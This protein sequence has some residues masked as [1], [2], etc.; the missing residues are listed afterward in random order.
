MRLF[1]VVQNSIRPWIPASSV[2]VIHR[3]AL[4]AHHPR[5]R[6]NRIFLGVLLREAEGRVHLGCGGVHLGGFVNIDAFAG[7]AADV[8][9]DCRQ[10]SLFEAS[11]LSLVYSNAFLEHLY[12]DERERLLCDIHRALR[13]KGLILF[14]GIPDIEAAARAYLERRAPGNLRPVFDTEELYRYT[15]GELQRGSGFRLEDLHK[16]PV[17]ASVL[18]A[19]LRRAGFRSGLVFRYRWGDEPVAVALGCAAV[20][21]DVAENVEDLARLPW[22]KE[23]NINWTSVETLSTL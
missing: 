14:S 19:L 17:D 22:P 10:M 3:F 18:S 4:K 12:Q 11:R 8:V 16:S 21:Q 20:K 7:P 6:V 1:R 13:P 15:H 9:A 23:A 2:A 5:C